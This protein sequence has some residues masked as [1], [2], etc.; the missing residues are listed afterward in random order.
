MIDNRWNDTNSI[1][2]TSGNVVHVRTVT[3][4]RNQNDESMTVQLSGHFLFYE[5]KLT[6][7]IIRVTGYT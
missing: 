4:N 7:F 5:S 6:C 3:Q 2:N 1:I